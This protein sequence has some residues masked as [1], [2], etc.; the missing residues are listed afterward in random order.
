LELLFIPITFVL[1]IKNKYMSNKQT[2]VQ[3]SGV[4]NEQTTII[5]NTYKVEAYD[6]NIKSA[7]RGGKLLSPS[8]QVIFDSVKNAIEYAQSNG[9]KAQITFPHTDYPL[10]KE[11]LVNGAIANAILTGKK[12]FSNISFSVVIDAVTKE[13]VRLNSSVIRVAVKEKAINEL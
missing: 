9:G 12:R 2:E 10:R 5:A 7:K 4:A 11:K 6:D 1:S 13:G 8:V 3:M